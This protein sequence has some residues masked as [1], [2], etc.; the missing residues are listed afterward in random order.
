MLYLTCPSTPGVRDVM[1]SGRLGAMMNPGDGKTNALLDGI[2]FAADNGCFADT[3]VAS[4]WIA[5]LEKRTKIQDACLF[6]VVPDVVA[7]FDGTLARWHVW[8]P[9]VRQM[10]YRVAFAAQDGMDLARVPWDDLD[11]WFTGGSDDWKLS[12]ESWEAMHEAK[13]RG[14]WCHLGRVNGAKK[15]RAAKAGGYDSADGTYLRFGPD[16]NLPKLLQWLSP[17]VLDLSEIAEGA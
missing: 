7:D 12:Q 17:G 11:V 2:T 16:V 15:L 5:S 6:A 10:G 14:K 13:R 8:A 3:W 9:V 4:K 1:R